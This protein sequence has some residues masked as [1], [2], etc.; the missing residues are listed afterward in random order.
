MVIGI[1]IE[2]LWGPLVLGQGLYGLGSRGKGLLLFQ[3][4]DL[5][6]RMEPLCSKDPTGYVGSILPYDASNRRRDWGCPW[7]FKLGAP[8]ALPHRA[9]KAIS[10]QMWQ[11]PIIYVSVRLVPERCSGSQHVYARPKL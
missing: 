6:V 11:V 3:F 8:R 9:L 1:V 10:L 7:T 2:G 4:R 5:G